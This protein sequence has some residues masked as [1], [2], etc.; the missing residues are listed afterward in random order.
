MIRK[1]VKKSLNAVISGTF[2]R[3]ENVNSDEM[4]LSGSSSEC[5]TLV[6]FIIDEPAETH[7]PES[8]STNELLE[9]DNQAWNS[10]GPWSLPTVPRLPLSAPRMTQWSDSQISLLDEEECSFVMPR[11]RT[12]LSGG[13]KKTSFNKRSKPSSKALG[14]CLPVDLL[15]PEERSWM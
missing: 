10:P 2:R 11:S 9:D 12:R 8:D 4:T 15:E 5:S 1:S 6:D 14:P 3:R 7:E 13:R